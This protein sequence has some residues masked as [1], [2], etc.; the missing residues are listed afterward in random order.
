MNQLPTILQRTKG[1]FILTVGDTTGFA[2][3]GVMVN[4]YQEG[5]R[6]RL[7]VN[8][9]SLQAGQI[10]VSSHVLKLAKIVD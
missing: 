6:L 9:R 5:D 10:A 1:H 2:Q 8:L 3:Q 4:F 7:E